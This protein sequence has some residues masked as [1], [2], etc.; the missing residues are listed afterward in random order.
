MLPLDLFHHLRSSFP[1][2]E[3][4]SILASLIEACPIN[5]PDPINPLRLPRGIDTTQGG[6]NEVPPPPPNQ[7][8]RFPFPPPPNEATQP[9][10]VD[11]VIETP[12]ATRRPQGFAAFHTAGSY[13]VSTLG[14]SDMSPEDQPRIATRHSVASGQDNGDPDSDDELTRNEVMRTL[15]KSILT[16]FESVSRVQLWRIWN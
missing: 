5:P 16:K 12:A 7:A 14:N 4:H 6:S 15:T 8:Q 11:E 9:S 10:L 3:Y 2:V 13:S 1:K